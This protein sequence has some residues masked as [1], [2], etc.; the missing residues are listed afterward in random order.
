MW[1]Q[2]GQ[3]NHE[4]A[5]RSGNTRVFFNDETG[6]TITWHRHSRDGDVLINEY[7]QHQGPRFRNGSTIYALHPNC[8][9]SAV[10]QAMSESRDGMIPGKIRGVDLLLAIARP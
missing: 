7:G 8:L 9:S 2:I 10:I 4:V 6:A 1:R 5:V 3:S